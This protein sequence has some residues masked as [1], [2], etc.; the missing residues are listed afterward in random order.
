ME[1]ELFWRGNT[2]SE[3]R[4]DGIAVAAGYDGYGRLESYDRTNI[5]AQSYT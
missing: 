1:D 2:V 5:G 3:S 4:P